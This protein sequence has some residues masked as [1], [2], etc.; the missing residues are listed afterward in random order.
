[1]SDL[2]G[3]GVGLDVVKT[4]LE[5]VKGSI[6]VRSYPQKGTIFSIQIR[7]SL[8][9]ARLLICQVDQVVYGFVSNEV[10][11]VLIPG[12]K[13]RLLAGQKVLDWNQEEGECTIPVYELS[14][15]FH[16]P[17]R[18]RDLGQGKGGVN[19]QDQALDPLL[20]T[21]DE[22]SPVL[23]L[24]TSEGLIGL[25]VDR[26][27][28]EQELV[29]KPISSAIVPPPYI[30]GCSILADGRLTLVIDGSSLVSYAQKKG[31]RLIQQASPLPE[32][33]NLP[34]PALSSSLST[35]ELGL[36]ISTHDTPEAT[37]PPPEKNT[38]E[39]EIKTILIVDDRSEKNTSEH[40]TPAEGT[41]LRRPPLAKT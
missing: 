24:N 4:Q 2:S 18:P 9:T 19:G 8:M 11:Q 22:I 40:P 36:F 23:L 35:Q 38:P 41:T 39:P 14:S 25:E 13:L 31:M 28:E 29:I 5:R 3:R 12:E 20:K 15:L 30:Y 1:M 33:E 17:T 7:E 10:E 27:V 26:V 21:P 16:Y 6:S 32:A 37:S 34:T